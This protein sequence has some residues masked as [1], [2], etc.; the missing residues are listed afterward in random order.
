MKPMT[1]LQ[2]IAFWV[3]FLESRPK[4]ACQIHKL[5]PVSH[6]IVLAEQLESLS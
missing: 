1:R 5:N 6:E 2:M 4:F 3:I